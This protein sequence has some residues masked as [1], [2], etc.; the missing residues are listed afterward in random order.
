MRTVECL[1]VASTEPYAG[2]TGVTAALLL[3]AAERGHIAGYFKPFGTMPITAGDHETDS[4]AAYLSSLAALKAPVHIVC[5]VVRTHELIE[6]VLAGEAPPVIDRVLE[7]YGIISK[8]VQVV[9]VEGPSDLSQ[10]AVF[11][12]NLQRLAGM[13][14]GRVLLVHRPGSSELPE[15]LVHAQDVLG[16][17][18]LGVL[19]NDVS[20][21]RLNATTTRV[22]DYLRSVGITVFGT[23]PHDSALSAVSVAE[24][25]SELDGVALAGESGLEEPVESFMVG[26]MGQEKALRY[27]R[28]RARK[29]VVTGGDRSDVQLAALETDTRCVICTGGM[30]PS[31]IVLSRADELGIP[32]VLVEMDTLSAVERMEVLFGHVRVHDANKVARIREL[33]GAHA[34]VDSLFAALGG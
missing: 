22:T 30:A 17:N 7:S 29:A 15:E 32:M 13:L 21:A 8:G 2:K 18:L 1:I 12:L 28:R 23:I 14:C 6:Q 11:G 26:A 9:F 20:Q 31:S 34:D 5:P 19:F 10:G 27:F 3:E 25:V 16:D 33:L 4:D 24:I